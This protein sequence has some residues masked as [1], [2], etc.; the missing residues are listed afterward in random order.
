M[1][2]Y[3]A[4]IIIVRFIWHCRKVSVANKE[5]V[6]WKWSLVCLDQKDEEIWKIQ[7]E[8]KSFILF[9]IIWMHIN[10]YNSHTAFLL[11][12]KRGRLAAHALLW[13]GGHGFLIPLLNKHIPRESSLSNVDANAGGLKKHLWNNIA[14]RHLYRKTWDQN[15]TF[16]VKFC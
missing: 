10:L 1:H 14:V 2:C 16:N 3:A 8:C 5:C 4:I 12:T 11:R 15:L 13:G 6:I 9:I 7:S